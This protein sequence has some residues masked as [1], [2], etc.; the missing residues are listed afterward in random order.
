MHC[1]VFF[2][3]G[4]LPRKLFTSPRDLYGGGIVVGGV[5]DLTYPPPEVVVVDGRP[6][7]AVE[8]DLKRKREDF[9]FID[10]EQVDRAVLG[11][12]R[13]KF[14]ESA[15]IG[16]WSQ[17]PLG[18]FAGDATYV[19]FVAVK[20]RETAQWTRH[21]HDEITESVEDDEGNWRDVVVERIPYVT[22]KPGRAI[23]TVL[24][25]YDA[26]TGEPLWGGCG[27]G[28]SVVSSRMGP[29]PPVPPLGFAVRSGVLRLARK[30]PRR[31][32][33]SWR[34]N[35]AESSDSLP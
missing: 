7:R 21:G 5:V 3:L 32:K 17:L 12:A 15:R 4:V 6:V 10:R 23:E 8:I 20:N 19:V 25:I 11:K 31:S 1:W 2:W 26:E 9:S 30:L 33:A 27:A 34:K 18:S 14:K 24:L 13:K 28:V 35:S 16:C 29:H 22:R